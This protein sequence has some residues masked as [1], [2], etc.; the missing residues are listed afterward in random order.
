MINVQ[1]AM[2]QEVRIPWIIFSWNREH[3]SYSV[4]IE[5]SGVDG[6]FG[7]L[8]LSD[9]VS[10]KRELCQEDRNKECFTKKQPA[11]KG[12]CNLKKEQ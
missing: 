12:G 3:F 8:S 4:L 1:C 6:L 7:K 9:D 5:R 11:G 2:L 10:E